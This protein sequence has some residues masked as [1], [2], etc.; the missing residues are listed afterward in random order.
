LTALA[1]TLDISWGIL[2]LLMWGLADFLVRVVAVRI[3][4]VSTAFFVQSI[5]LAVPGAGLA[6]LILSSGL[7]DVTW[8]TIAWLVPLMPLLSSLA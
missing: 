5:G 7:G 4:S 2:T 6:I 1:F 3:G 8:L